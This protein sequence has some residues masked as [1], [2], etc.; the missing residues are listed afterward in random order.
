MTI[1]GM[2]RTKIVVRATQFVP[3]PGTTRSQ[4]ST[5]N[6][7]DSCSFAASVQLDDATNAVATEETSLECSLYGPR[8][9]RTPLFHRR[10]PLHVPR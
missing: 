5:V 7:T 4:F 1:R 10:G 8:S 9:P 6:F 3:K 2:A